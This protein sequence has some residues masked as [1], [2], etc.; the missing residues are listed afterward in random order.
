MVHKY[1]FPKGAV[2]D[3]GG[4]TKEILKVLWEGLT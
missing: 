1:K 3:G 2:Q 4:Q